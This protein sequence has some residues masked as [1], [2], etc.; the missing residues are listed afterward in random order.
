M[1]HQAQLRADQGPL[2][3]PHF[4]IGDLLST[5]LE[6][7]AVLPTR[8]SPRSGR[9]ERTRYGA[10]VIGPSG[11]ALRRLLGAPV[12]ADSSRRSRQPSGE[13]AAP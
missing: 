8:R 11:S 6:H 10:G 1:D 9:K 7:K 5:L 3:Q 2:N 13:V 12:V 4:M